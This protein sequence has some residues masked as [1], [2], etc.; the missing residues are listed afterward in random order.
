[1]IP[2]KDLDMIIQL[3]KK[4]EVSFKN[5]MRKEEYRRVL[6]EVKRSLHYTVDILLLSEGCLVYSYV[7]ISDIFLLNCYYYLRES[8][9]YSIVNHLPDIGN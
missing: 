5:G 2:D 6:R 9:D 8:R 1:M 7:F 4:K 3:W